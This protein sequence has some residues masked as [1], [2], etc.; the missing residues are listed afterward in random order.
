MLV[1]QAE[2]S[3]SEVMPRFLIG[4]YQPFNKKQD[5]GG[6][7]AIGIGNAIIISNYRR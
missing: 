1:A 2:A 7:L 6:E 3:G 5:L 4:Q